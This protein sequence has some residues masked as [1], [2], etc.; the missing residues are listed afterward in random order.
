[1]I[2]KT[3]YSPTSEHFIHYIWRT[4]LF[5]HEK[6]TLVDGSPI[7]IIDY[8]Q[9][10][11]DSGPDFLH[12]KIKVN[13]TLF[14]G[15]IEMHLKSSDWNLH[16]HQEDPA[17]N[18]VILHVV[19]KH[20]SEV[21]N[22]QGQSIFSL[23]IGPRIDAGQ[24]ERYR[25]IQSHQGWIPCQPLNPASVPGIIWAIW[26][27]RLMVERL[28]AKISWVMQQMDLTTGHWEEVFYR[29]LLRTMGTNVNREA[30]AELAGRLDYK[31]LMRHQG[32]FMECLAMTF[33]LAG[34]LD[35]DYDDEYAIQLHDTFIF[36]KEKYGFVPMNAVSWKYHRMHPPNF[37]D[38][39]IAQ[40]T[41]MIC[42]RQNLFQA[43]VENCT[44]QDIMDILELTMPDAYWNEHFILGVRSK[45]QEKY[46]TKDMKHLIIINAVSP[47]LFLYGEVYHKHELQEKAL[48]LLTHIPPE[49]NKIVDQWKHLGVKVLNAVDSQ[50]LLQL[51]TTYCDQKAC[52][53]CAI[54]HQLLKQ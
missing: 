52:L 31:I 16:R 33:G 10:N 43:M 1:M 48:A 25:S 19:G 34:L 27:E 46:F 39:R 53:Q 18:S 41:A 45:Y 11:T 7:E 6:L 15:H 40:A 23:E 17:Y 49:K 29:Q 51:K 32:E 50:S 24:G 12:G 47:V 9:Y 8:G 26:K 54:G 28:Q 2:Q 42:K 36:L 37:P 14:A 4:K 3:I 44:Y 22:Q 30:F 38:T 13:G 21:Y 35:K 20:E 5:N